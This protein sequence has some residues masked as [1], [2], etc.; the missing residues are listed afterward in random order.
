MFET[1]ALRE[2]FDQ[3][4][5]AKRLAAEQL[6]R[7]AAAQTD[8]ERRDRLAELCSHAQRHVEL[9]ERLLELVS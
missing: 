9:T 2:E 7:L 4:L 6:D 1:E 5:Q 3:I 8:G